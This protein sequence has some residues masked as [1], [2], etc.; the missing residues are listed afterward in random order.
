MTTAAIYF[1]PDGY[2]TT[3]D[4]L[5]GRHAA[6]A[7]FLRAFA[8]T[9]LSPHAWGHVPQKRFAPAF[10]RALREAGYAGQIRVAALEAHAR[11]ADPGCVYFPGPGLGDFAWRRMAA[12]DRAYSLCGVTHTTASH[13]AMDAIARLMTAPL[14]EWDALVCTSN[15]VRDSLRVLLEAQADYLRWR[16]GATRFELPQLPLIPLGVHCADYV[17]PAEERAR[18]RAALGIAESDVVAL[19]VGRLSFHAKAHP[20]PM[21]LALE[22]T[23]TSLPGAKIH[24]IQCGWFANEAIAAAFRDG[25]AALCPSVVQHVLDGRNEMQRRRAWASADLFVSLS[26]NIQ[27]TFGL[28]PIEAMAS[29]LPVVV[30]DWD[31]YRDTVRDGIDGFRIPTL[32]PPPPAGRDLA[33]RHA[34]GIDSYDTYCGHTCEFVAVDTEA[35]AVAIRR[36]AENPALR[37]QL[38][39][40]GRL[41]A[42]TTF[43]WNGLL[44]TYRALWADLAQRRLAS[45]DFPGHSGIIEPP[46][47]MDPF[48]MFQGYA[49]RQLADD[50]RLALTANST[51]ELLES[52]RAL[53]MNAF[54]R[55]VLPSPEDC[56]ELMTAIAGRPDIRCATLLG[57]FPAAQ[58]ETLRRGL[59]WMMKMNILRL[60]SNS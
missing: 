34:A 28:T 57:A 40:A 26:D 55:Q 23:A 29:G 54:A 4:K 9:E 13:A 33:F 11:L 18:A 52:R 39:D 24:L 3:G 51:P 16:L 30:S 17:F 49:T 15:A 31:G 46:E 45:A 56:R 41:R 37:R 6:G 8:A 20:G 60:P 50:D 53:E 44:N 2:Q 25:A 1:T 58:R 21:F 12:G 43:D 48:R 5:M 36:L 59:V 19:F 42:R 7:G 14:R 27:E 22:D 38:G 47:R 35:A 32:T 10:G